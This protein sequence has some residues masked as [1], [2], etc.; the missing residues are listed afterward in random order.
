[1]ETNEFREFTIRS[2]GHRNLFTCR[3]RNLRS[4]VAEAVR[5][6][7]ELG[8]AILLRAFLDETCLEGANLDGAYLREA[9]LRR[10]NLERANLCGADLEW[11]N[12]EGANL[13]GAHLDR[14]CLDGSILRGADLFDAELDGASLRGACLD[15][16]VVNWSSHDLVSEI[17]RRAAGNDIE[18]LKIA[19]LVAVC[20][21]ECWSEFLSLRR[22]PLFAWAIDSLAE[23][24]RPDDGAPSFLRERAD[25][26]APAQAGA[27]A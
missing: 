15:G 20:R 21:D 13:K 18:R 27:T 2:L 5:I 10:A 9:S 1:M 26:I 17:L 25:E 16:I 11:A 22:D 3:A 7:E 4:A 19:G 6:G 24:V 23:W 14:A 12:L 8:M